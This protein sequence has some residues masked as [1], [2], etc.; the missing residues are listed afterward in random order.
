[1]YIIEVLYKLFKKEQKLKQ[2]ALYKKESTSEEVS[3]ESCEHTFLPIDSTKEVLACSKCGLV[4]KTQDL[5]SDKN[6]FMR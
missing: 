3:Y 5:K 2:E 4:V 1:M 6:F